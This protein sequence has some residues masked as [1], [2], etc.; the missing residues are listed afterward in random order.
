M[1]YFQ[2]VTLMRR[3]HVRKFYIYLLLYICYSKKAQPPQ[4]TIWRKFYPQEAEITF[5]TLR[6]G[7]GSHWSCPAA[8]TSHGS[9]D[10]LMAAYSFQALAPLNEQKMSDNIWQSTAC[11]FGKPRACHVFMNCAKMATYLNYIL[12]GVAISRVTPHMGICVALDGL[13]PFGTA[14]RSQ[15]SGNVLCEAVQGSLLWWAD[16][17]AAMGAAGTDGTGTLFF[18]FKFVHFD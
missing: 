8:I 18:S 17:L 12:L 3:K 6:A 1:N 15:Y 11:M 4:W 5:L 16:I 7:C 13:P 10:K 14:V 2:S 9:S